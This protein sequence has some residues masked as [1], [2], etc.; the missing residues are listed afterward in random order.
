LLSLLG[1]TDDGDMASPFDRHRQ[2]TL[3]THAISRNAAWHDPATLR[4]EIPQQPGILKINRCLIQAK[5][6]GPPS[7]KQPASTSTTFAVIALH[8]RLLVLCH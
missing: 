5:P 4:Q 6:A 1:K 3:M 2:L 7:L 8:R